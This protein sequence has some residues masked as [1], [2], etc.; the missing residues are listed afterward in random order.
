MKKSAFFILALIAVALPGNAQIYHYYRTGGAPWD[1]NKSYI[2]NV[3]TDFSITSRNFGE[4]TSGITSN[5]GLALSFRYEGDKNINE[6]FTWG[7]QTEVSYL[8]Q[9][10]KYNKIDT[11][12]GNTKHSDLRWWDLEVDLRLS[13]AYWIGDN[14]ELQAAAGIYISPYFGISG[15]SYETTT[16]GAEVAGSRKKEEGKSF[17]FGTGISTMLQAKYF[18]NENFFL[19]LNLHDNIGVSLFGKDFAIGG[20]SSQGGQ[21]GVVLFGIGYKFIR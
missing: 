13:L 7:Y 9:N 16:A 17:N 1:G 11:Y 14:I 8:A 18:F 12:S 20:N 15:E 5:P 10:F 19:S 2:L 3:G 6:R 4:N 21:R